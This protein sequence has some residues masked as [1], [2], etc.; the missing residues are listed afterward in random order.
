MFKKVI[1]CSSS[2]S[3]TSAITPT[4]FSYSA[5]ASSYRPRA[6]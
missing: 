4:A 2:P 5:S 3:G 1:A 6:A